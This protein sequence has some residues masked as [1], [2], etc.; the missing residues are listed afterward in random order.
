MFARRGFI[1][2]L[3]SMHRLNDNVARWVC[4]VTKATAILDAEPVQSLW[5]GYGTIWRCHIEGGPSTPSVVVKHVQWPSARRHPRGWATDR[6]HER[7]V[8]SYAVEVAWYE[9]YARAC[10]T[11]CRVP[12]CFGT[13]SMN[14]GVLLALEDLDDAG[15]SRRGGRDRRDILGCLSWL[16]HFHATFFERAPE[17]LWPEGTYW[18]LDTRPDEWDALPPGPLKDAA[19]ELAR[20]LREAPFPT[21]IHGDAKVANFCFGA[22]GEVAAVDFQYVGGGCGMK[23]VAYFISSCVSEREADSVAPEL[24]DHYFA[25]LREAARDIDVD[26][27]EASW[28][29]L[30]PVAWTDFYRFL[31]GWS[32]GHPKIHSYSERLARQVL[33]AHRPLPL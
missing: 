17:G 10:G 28:R 25:C 9:R 11:G 15:L 13:R 31:Q 24:L 26:G 3:S 20:R 12:R 29:P 27:L 32:P 6:S 21:L 23:D 16:A 8:R 5:S 18:H 4:A 22:P 7:K 1:G 14:D 2:S 30:Y 19:P 33:Q